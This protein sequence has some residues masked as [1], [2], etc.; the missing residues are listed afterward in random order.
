[1]SSDCGS[2]IHL[3]N[4]KLMGN[5]SVSDQKRIRWPVD[6]I[7]AYSDQISG[8]LGQ[9]INRF[10]SACGTHKEKSLQKA[11][12]SEFQEPFVDPGVRIESSNQ[13]G[14]LFVQN[15]ESRKHIE[16]VE[17]PF[18]QNEAFSPSPKGLLLPLFLDF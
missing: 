3:V 16:K 17:V 2:A 8:V 11:S 4:P 5:E 13:G 14:L 1:M 15:A 18:L 6:G 7:E 10:L 9:A 12:S